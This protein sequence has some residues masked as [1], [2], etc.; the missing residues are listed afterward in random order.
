MSKKL[1]SK[2]KKDPYSYGIVNKEVEL[3]LELI[4][5][6]DGILIYKKKFYNYGYE[7]LYYY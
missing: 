4:E 6:R 3:R 7:S 2:I 1:C 5:E